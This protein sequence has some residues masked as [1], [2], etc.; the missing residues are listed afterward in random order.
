MVDLKAVVKCKKVSTTITSTLNTTT[1]ELIHNGPTGLISFDPFICSE[2][3]C[4]TDMTYTV[5]SKLK[6]VTLLRII[7]APL[8]RIIWPDWALWKK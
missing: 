7:Q 3:K 8:L 5:T 1:I 2:P 4:C 6:N